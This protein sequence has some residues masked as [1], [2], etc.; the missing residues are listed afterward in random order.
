MV[1]K[2]ENDLDE[3]FSLRARNQH[4]RRDQEIRLPEL[5]MSG[6]VLQGFARGAA[7]DQRVELRLLC[8]A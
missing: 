4:G 5:L 2:I 8:G 3:V 1:D 6:E 7:E